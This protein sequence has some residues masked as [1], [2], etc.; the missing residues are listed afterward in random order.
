MDRKNNSIFQKILVI[1]IAI[2]VIV[3]F[4]VFFYMKKQNENY[5]KIKISPND[6]LVYT[7]YQSDDDLYSVLVPYI[8]IKGEIVEAINQ[9]IDLFL[10]EFLFSGYSNISYEYSINGKILSVIIKV[11]DYNT[12]YAPQPYFRGYNINLDTLELISDESLLEFFDVNMDFVSTKISSQLLSYYNELIEQ[13]YYQEAECNF[14]CFLKYRGIDNVLDNIVFY[15]KEGKLIAYRPFT[16]V[17]IYGEEEYFKDKDF[18]FIII[19]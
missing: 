8:N 18:E 15:V 9:D 13:N 6:Y 12:D 11:I 5:Q 17:S 1:S 10:E 7:K 19:E 3:F 14:S 4:I 2:F 16:F